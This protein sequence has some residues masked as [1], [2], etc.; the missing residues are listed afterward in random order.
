MWHGV[1]LAIQFLTIIPIRMQ[2]DWNERTARVAV[3]SFPFVG[4]IIGLF[5]V[6]IHVVLSDRLF[7]R[8]YYYF[9][10][11]FFQEDCTRTDGWIV[12]MHIFRIVIDSDV[13][14]L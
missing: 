2:V 8:F 4:A 13:S 14:I 3:L 6:A 1:V 7:C 10:L 5:L 9:P 11:S 12:A